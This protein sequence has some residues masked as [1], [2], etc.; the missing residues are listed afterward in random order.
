MTPVVS[1]HRGFFVLFFGDRYVFFNATCPIKKNILGQASRIPKE[2]ALE[3]QFLGPY[4]NKI[5]IVGC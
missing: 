2:Q 5:L 4:Q 3:A 1:N